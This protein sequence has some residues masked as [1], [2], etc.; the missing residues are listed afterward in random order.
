MADAA[1]Q[2]PR[3][4]SEREAAILAFLL[5]V[6]TSGVDAL[7]RQ[8][9]TATVVGKCECGCATIY[10]AVDRAAAASS[11]LPSRVAIEAFSHDQGSETRSYLLLFLDDGW[12]DR[13]EI[14]W[15]G[16]RVPPIEFPPP[17]AFQPPRL[18]A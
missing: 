18:S 1:E 11:P 5:S 6:E 3:P 7:R 10:L 17:D 13:V 2:F 9:A 4:L 15:H 14:F 8:A 16:D 12:L